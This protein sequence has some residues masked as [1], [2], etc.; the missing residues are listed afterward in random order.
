MM[1][2]SMSEWDTEAIGPERAGADKVRTMNLMLVNF[3]ALED[4]PEIV[5]ARIHRRDGFEGKMNSGEVKE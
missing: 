3:T 2:L 1:I 4:I 5:W